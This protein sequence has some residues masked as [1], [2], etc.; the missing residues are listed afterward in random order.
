[1]DY[2]KYYTPMCTSRALVSYLQ[3]V[4]EPSNVIDICCGSCNLL[5]AAKERWNDIEMTGVD[6]EPHQIS[7]VKFFNMDGRKYALETKKRYELVLANP[8]FEN[9]E[10]GLYDKL[11]AQTFK[12]CK[13]SR[14]ENEMLIANLKILKRNGTLLAIM[15]STFIEGERNCEIRK[16]IARRYWIKDIIK[17]PQDTFANTNIKTY[18]I[19]IENQKAKNYSCSVSLMENVDGQLRINHL[20]NISYAD[21]ISGRWS[22]ESKEIPENEQAIIFRGNISSKE[23]VATGK[24]IL[25]TSVMGNGWK[26]SRRCVNEVSKQSKYAESGDIVVSRIGKSAGKWCKYY[27]E[28]LPISDCLFVIKDPDNS[29]S[30]SLQGKDFTHLVKGVATSYI[31]KKDIMVWLFSNNRKVS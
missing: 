17:L 11:Y 5:Y 8:P 22:N 1:M 10:S 21:V 16:N 23:F 6:L 3:N 30:R 2:S 28:K 26:P 18:A 20:R 14:L 9:M 31:T 12:K 19:I 27:G 24:E 7:D 25:H 15:P 13:T 4:N 29:I